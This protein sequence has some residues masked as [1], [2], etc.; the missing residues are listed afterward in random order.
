MYADRRETG[1]AHKTHENG[2][3]MQTTEN[4][5]F[6]NRYRPEITAFMKRVVGERPL[7]HYQMMR[8]HLGWETAEG[9]PYAG[10]AG[11]MV[12]PTLCLLTCEAVGG[13]YHRA[14]PA[15]AAIELLHNFSLIHDDIE[16]N[17]TERHGRKT[18]WSLWGVAQAINVGDGMFAL[19][20]AAMYQ[21]QDENIPP[22]QVLAAVRMLE[23]ACLEL[24]EGQHRDISFESRLDVTLAEYLE[25]VSG[26]TGALMGAAAGIGAL[27]GG[28]S[29]ETVAA[30][31]RFGHHLGIAFQI[32]DDYLGIWG[33]P[34]ATGKPTGDDIRDRKKSF[35][36]LHALE[37]ATAEDRARLRSLY[38]EQHLSE[39]D[40]DTVVDIL[41]RSR[42]GEATLAEAR[43]RANDA[44]ALLATLDLVPERRQELAELVSYMVWRHS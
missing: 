17:S 22:N 13:D 27:L 31:Q 5:S 36:V 20:H 10:T 44:L 14:L 18:V 6:L 28:G 29:P 33:E 37:T 12:R 43:H 11:K 32:Y 19:A 9:R 34:A 38:R 4:L 40:I 3:S 8:Y 24:C 30:L 16:D 21:L 39:A 35:P 7:A 2:L 25:M 42:A 1:G 26:K 23:Q 15:A 41:E